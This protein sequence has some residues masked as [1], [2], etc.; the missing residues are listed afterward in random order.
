MN[1]LKLN[2]SFGVETQVW[3]PAANDKSKLVNLTT[4]EVRKR[5]AFTQTKTWFKARM[6]A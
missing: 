6:V 1:T 3:E 5:S 2:S 4:G